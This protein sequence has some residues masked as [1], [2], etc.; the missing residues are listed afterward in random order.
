MSDWGGGHGIKAKA[1]AEVFEVKAKAKV[2]PL[3]GQD[4]DILFSR[5]RTV[6]EGAIHALISGS[7]TK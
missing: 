2:R 3:R 6:L 1:K 7:F 5:W 4:H